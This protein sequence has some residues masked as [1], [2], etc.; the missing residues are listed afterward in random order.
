MMRSRFAQ[1]DSVS[2]TIS[3][4]KALDILPEHVRDTLESIEEMDIPIYPFI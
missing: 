1:K 3:L 4:D 2:I